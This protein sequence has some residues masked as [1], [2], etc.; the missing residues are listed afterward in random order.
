MRPD[1]FMIF[2]RNNAN[3][4]VG[5]STEPLVMIQADTPL[6]I[7]VLS[8]SQSVVART[9]QIGVGGSKAIHEPIRVL[10]AVDHATPKLQDAVERAYNDL[11]VVITVFHRVGNSS[12]ASD[13]WKRQPLFEYKLSEAR[14]AGVEAVLDPRVHGIAGTMWPSD[15]LD[16]GPLEEVIV[17]YKKFEMSYGTTA[18]KVSWTYAEGGG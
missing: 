15:V 5:E 4:I 2:Q 9:G 12:Q 14:V 13:Q 16:V 17:S 1:A 7:E 3:I 10:K 18:N 8:F 11:S 6:G